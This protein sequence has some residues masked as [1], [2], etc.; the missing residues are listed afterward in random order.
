MSQRTLM[1]FLNLAMGRAYVLPSRSDPMIDLYISRLATRDRLTE[2]STVKD[3]VDLI[4]EAKN[5]LVLTGAGISQAFL[6]V[7]AS[8]C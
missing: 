1:Y 6:A 7:F 8:I 5:I 4:R 2:Y 3:A